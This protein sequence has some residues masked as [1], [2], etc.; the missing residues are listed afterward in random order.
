MA[1]LSPG[2]SRAGNGTSSLC[3]AARDSGVGCCRWET[4]SCPSMVLPPRTGRWR[5]LTSCCGMRRWPTG[6][7]W[8]SSLMWQVSECPYLPPRPWGPCAPSCPVLSPGARAPP[9]PPHP[10]AQRPFCLSICSV[11]LSTST[12]K[13]LAG[14]AGI[15]YTSGSVDE[16]VLCRSRTEGG[17]RG[18]QNIPCPSAGL[19]Q[20]TPHKNS[21]RHSGLV[22][23]TFCDFGHSL[24]PPILS[25]PN[26]NW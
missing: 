7:H 2:D 16:G 9:P 22:I 13:A 15:L 19:R 5:K 3:G 24:P 1:F 4:G 14:E 20:R 12:R 21:V 10:P 11:C 25:F 26:L 8:R 6:S 17:Q 23:S 18:A